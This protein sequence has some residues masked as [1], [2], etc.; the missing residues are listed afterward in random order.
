MAQ[1]SDIPLDIMDK[2]LRLSSDESYRSFCRNKLV[3]K[4][5]ISD[6]P[7]QLKFRSIE[8]F[9]KNSAD[10]YTLAQ[11]RDQ[12]SVEKID[13]L[14]QFKIM[15][16]AESHLHPGLFAWSYKTI[17]NSFIRGNCHFNDEDEDKTRSH[18]LAYVL[19]KMSDKK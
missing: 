18:T 7:F 17:L 9:Y 6:T 19:T 5:A 2:I 16:E 4:H 1:T 12:D 8:E 14:S 3:C 11:I 13:F 10:K 15:V